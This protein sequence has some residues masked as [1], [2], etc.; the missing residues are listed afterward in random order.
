[1]LKLKRSSNESFRNAMPI[2]LFSNRKLS[3]KCSLSTHDLSIIK[4]QY[5]SI[6]NN[7]DY[8]SFPFPHKNSQRFKSRL[9]HPHTKLQENKSFTIKVSK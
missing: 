1:M 3:K 6:F 5:F 2:K 8:L 9:N 7:N 4:D